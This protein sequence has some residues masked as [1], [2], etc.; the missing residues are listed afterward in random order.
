[1]FNNK[2]KKK[3]FSKTKKGAQ[4]KSIQTFSIILPN[5]IHKSRKK[6]LK[7]I[8]FKQAGLRPACFFFFHL[9]LARLSG[10]IACGKPLLAFWVFKNEK[11][12]K[13]THF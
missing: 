12:R 11:V 8:K 10:G 3:Y 5:L 1:L 7:K 6:N 13:I 9:S 4:I 2:S